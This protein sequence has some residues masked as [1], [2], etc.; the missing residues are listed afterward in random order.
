VSEDNERAVRGSLRV[1][2]E[3][4]R[5]RAKNKLSALAERQ[6]ATAEDRVGWHGWA[7][8]NV[9][10]LWREERVVAECVLI[11]VEAKVLF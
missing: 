7:V 2:C 4:L 5:V 11:S 6:A 10:A 1:L 9:E 3:A 8:G